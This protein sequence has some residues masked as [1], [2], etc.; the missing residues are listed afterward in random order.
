MLPNVMWNLLSDTNLGWLKCNKLKLRYVYID[1][2]TS[3]EHILSTQLCHHNTITNDQGNVKVVSK[4]LIKS[5][6]E[7]D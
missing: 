7:T 5:A 6:E 4:L 2:S 1:I 3:K